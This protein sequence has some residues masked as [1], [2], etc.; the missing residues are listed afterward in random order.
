[1]CPRP[2]VALGTVLLTAA[3][4]TITSCGATTGTNSQNTYTVAEPVTSIKIGN[5]VGYTDIEGTDTTVVAVTEQITYTGNRPHT[6]HSIT[7]DQLAFNYTCPSGINVNCGV[8][9]MVKV[10]RR[11]AVQIDDKVG[12]VTLI[13]LAGQL[14]V[15]S[16]T[17]K[18]DATGLTS[19][20]V[21]ARASAGTITLAFTAPPT[22]VSVQTQVGSVTVRLPA[23]TTYAVDAGSQVGSVEVTVQR[24]SG[25]THR[26]AVHSEVGSVT[27]NNG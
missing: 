7:D 22:T 27:V 20:A 8:S 19:E 12:G 24:D 18:I 16:S 3:A 23:S 1:M 6:S 2:I 13:G 4:L 25:S 10:P 11:I 26:V 5:P 9:Y 21:T 14:N 15:T 17:G